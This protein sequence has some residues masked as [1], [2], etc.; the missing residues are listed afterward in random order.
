MDDAIE[1]LQRLDR[2]HRDKPVP[3]PVLGRHGGDRKGHA[4]KAKAGDDITTNRGTSAAYTVA[5]LRRDAP[6][7]AARVDRGEL[8]ANRAA[9]E[10]GFR[11]ATW[12]APVALEQLAEAL[13][14]RYP[15]KFKQR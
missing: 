1:R 7:L 6:E 5:R 2:L 14:R 15:G 12:R 13:E 10:A 11:A 3:A 8:T 4:A 9:I